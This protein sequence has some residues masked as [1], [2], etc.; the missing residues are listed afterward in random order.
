MLP[1]GIRRDVL[2]DRRLGVYGGDHVLDVE[3][4]YDRYW[5][6]VGGGEDP[7]DRVTL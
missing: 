4:E 5:R 2:A 6:S 1:R 7:A 3:G